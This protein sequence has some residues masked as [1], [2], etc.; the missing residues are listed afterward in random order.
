M[1]RLGASGGAIMMEVAAGPGHRDCQ[2]AGTSSLEARPTAGGE[3]AT[4][5]ESAAEACVA[6]LLASWHSVRHRP[7]EEEARFWALRA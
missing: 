3:Q 5:C 4:A 1:R 6:H 7:S 2:C